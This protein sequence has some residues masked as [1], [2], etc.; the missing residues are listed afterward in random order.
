MTR[1]NRRLTNWWTAFFVAFIPMSGQAQPGPTLTYQGQLSSIGGEAVNA[2]REMTFRIYAAAEGN[3]VLWAS[4]HPA[5]DVVDGIFTAV[6]GSRAPFDGGL[7]DQ[8]EL[9]LGVT[10]GE[11][12]EMTPRMRIGGALKSQWAAVA[13]HARDVRGEDIHPNSVSINDTPVID[14]SGRWVGSPVGLRGPTGPPG[15]AG[16]SLDLNQ[17]TDLDGVPDWIEVAVGTNP[18]DENDLPVMGNDDVADLLQVEGPPGPRGPGGISIASAVINF[19]GDLILTFTDTNTMNAGRVLGP[20]GIPGTPGAGGPAGPPG[21]DGVSVQQATIDNAGNLILG[22][23]DGNN[24]NAGSVTGPPGPAGQDSAPGDVA[25]NLAADAAFQGNVAETIV[26]N[27]A[28][29]L[30]DAIGGVAGGGKEGSGTVSRISNQWVLPAFGTAREYIHLLNPS[31]PK[32]L[33]YLYGEEPTGFSSTNS[34]QVTSKYSP[35]GA[36]G[37][38]FGNAGDAFITTANGGI[39]N[40]GDHLLLHQTVHPTE[41]GKWELGVVTSISGRQIN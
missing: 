18:T 36:A 34:L 4:T 7:T 25:A 1:L 31:M 19:D 24:L 30:G 38:L 39:F 10:I 29:A 37:G 13:D 27:H 5:V 2:S 6:L 26:I 22:L 9:Y 20:R 33:M 8:P 12:V 14:A 15:A 16:P 28:D 11:D 41:A 17:D 21:A 3:Q 23:S 32:V 40:V 35:N